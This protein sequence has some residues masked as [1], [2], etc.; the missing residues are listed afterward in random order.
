MTDATVTLSAEETAAEAPTPAAEVAL[1]LAHFK[2]AN[3]QV[4]AALARADA[5]TIREANAQRYLGCA[6]PDRKSV[7]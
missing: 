1:G 5:V 3:E 4:R 2:E 7:V 6:L